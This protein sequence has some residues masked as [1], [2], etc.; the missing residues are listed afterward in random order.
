MWWRKAKD[1]HGTLLGCCTTS[2]GATDTDDERPWRQ[3][4]SAGHG[5]TACCVLGVVWHHPLILELRSEESERLCVSG[6][7]APS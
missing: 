2:E 6:V 4:V 7:V 5:G 3:T 1:K